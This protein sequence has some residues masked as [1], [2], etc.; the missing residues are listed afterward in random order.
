M[1]FLGLDLFLNVSSI[2]TL[3]S[4]VA[5]AFMPSK[6]IANFAA[7]IISINALLLSLF[8]LPAVD[9]DIIEFSINTGAFLGNT[10]IY[11][12]RLSAWFILIV[13]FTSFTGAIYGIGYL[14]THSETRNKIMLHWILFILFHV[15]MVWVCMLK[16]AFAFLIAWEIMSLTST[17]LVIF[18]HQNPKTIKA[19]INYF[20]QMHISVVLLTIGFIWVYSQT[21]SFDFDA[22]GQ[23]FSTNPNLWLFLIFFI[24][25]GIKAGFV[26][27]HTWLPHAHPA[28]PS[29]VSGVMS[30]VIVKMGIYG[31]FRMVSFLKADYLLIGEIIITVSIISGLYGILNASVRRDFKQILAYCTIEN[32]GIIGIGIGI[33]LLGIGNN[34][35][36]LY[37]LGF[38]GA[39]LH[40][41]NHSLFKSLLF[42]SAGSIY[43][44]THTRNIDKL[45][46]LIKYM[47]K[48]AIFFLIG[49][50]A[51]GGI[52]P[53]NGFIS[54]FIIYSGLIE[55]LKSNNM[56]EII[57]LVL[58]FAGVSVIGGLS[59]LTFT[60]T[61]GTIFL[62]SAREILHQKPNEVSMYMLLPQYLIVFVMLSIVFFSSSYLSFANNIS[63]SLTDNSFSVINPD[64]VNYSQ[65]MTSISLYSILFIA[66]IAFIYGIRY[67]AIKN[68]EQ[69]FQPTW[70][71]GYVAPN[72]KMQY[73][74]KSF[75]KPL[76]KIFSFLLIENKQ[77][78]EIKQ[79]EIFPVQKRYSSLY[80]DFIETRLINPISHRMIYCVNYFKFIQN[81][82]IQSYVI[83][84]I[85]FILVIFILTVLNFV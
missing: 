38:G 52:P 82:R 74:G 1:Q 4:I 7:L 48:T 34:S 23:F 26:P 85:I 46:G 70:G 29:H 20:V 15:S 42:Y 9:G 21:G 83:Y 12:D 71:C 16:N 77:Y 6:F 47:P 43:Q 53:F 63:S 72:S 25:F 19:G 45:G 69:Q 81:G 36:L 18:D 8:V 2:I 58:T 78:S 73:S 22:I 55:G 60:K 28:A 33:G 76:S 68:K 35:L 50:L 57:L 5:F 17:L 64:L 32:I 84:G 11:I 13:N 79:N 56:G 37:Y 54:E 10:T 44:Q 80:I 14:K 65:I 3:I 59:I 75:S 27:L 30:G 40:V 31:I 66:F 49:S 41:L 24:G 61:F 51:I 62:G 39:L 67:L